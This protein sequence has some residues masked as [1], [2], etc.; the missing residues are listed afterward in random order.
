MPDESVP[1]AAPPPVTLL[2][3]MTGYWV[4]QALYAVAKLGVADLLIDGPQSV[5]HLAA[6]TQA[7]ATS[8]RRVLRAWGF[9]PKQAPA[10]IH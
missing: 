9:S 7:H 10:F 1:S 8:L 5:E 6:A 4:S 2:K 3:M